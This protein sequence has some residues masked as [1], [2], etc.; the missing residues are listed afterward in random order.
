MFNLYKEVL[1]M[2]QV[3]LKYLFRKSNNSIIKLI[4]TA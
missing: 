4:I 2:K 3:S 1:E